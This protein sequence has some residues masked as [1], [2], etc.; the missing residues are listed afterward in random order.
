MKID[1]GYTLSYIFISLT[2]FVFGAIL[3]YFNLAV[4]LIAVTIGALFLFVRTGTIFDPINSRIGRYH[5]LFGKDKIK[6]T[7]ISNFNKAHLDFEFI[8][9]KMNSRGSSS[10]VRTKTYTLTS[11]GKNRTKKFHEYSN[12]ETSTHILQLLKQEFHIEIIDKYKNI[13]KEAFN[14]RRKR[15]N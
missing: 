9:Q 15:K 6:W 7:S 14:R 8:S 13:Q 4:G 10:T 11:I 2:F 5:S 12:Y 3:A 1:E